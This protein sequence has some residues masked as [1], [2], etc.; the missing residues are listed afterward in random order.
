M[1][2]S[3][4]KQFSIYWHNVENAPVILDVLAREDIVYGSS[5]SYMATDLRPVFAEE[6]FLLSVILPKEFSDAWDKSIWADKSSHFFIDGKKVKKSVSQA[7]NKCN[8]DIL[9]KKVQD[10]IPS[11]DILLEEQEQIERFI[12]C[13]QLRLDKIINDQNYDSEGWP[14]GAVPFILEAV[15]RNKSR[16]PFVSFSGGKDST[17]VSHLVMQALSNPSIIHIFGDTTLE[18]PETYKYIYRFRSKHNRTPFFIE[19]NDASNFMDLCKKIGP[20][21]RVKSWCC[22]IFKTGPMGTTLADMGIDLLTFY[23]VRRLESTSRSKYKRVTPSPKLE[24]QHVAA[25]IIDWLDIDVWLYILAQKL[26]FNKAYRYGFSRVG[27][28]CC[29]NNSNW[30]DMLT[31]VY[32]PENYLEWNNFLVDF[33]RQIGKEDAEIY[34]KDGKWK[35]RH[36]GEGLDVHMTKVNS[37]NCTV[38]NNA[39]QYNLTRPLSNEF[40]ELFKPFGKLDFTLGR[41]Q[42]SEVFVISKQND[43]LLKISGAPKG[44]TVRITIFPAFLKLANSFVNI[45][46][47]YSYIERQIRKFQTCMYC[48]ACNSVCPVGAL[49]VTDGKYEI[50]DG[51]CIHC[52]KCVT[53]FPAGCLL[54]SALGTKNNMEIQE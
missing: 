51:K 53:H 22:S 10:F 38:E 18:F 13:N 50:N 35:A 23:G 52:L 41:A 21:S 36:G 1:A 32:N 44:R 29:P 46:N 19:R 42:L 16:H 12:R 49:K 17:V 40:Y 7:L 15:K 47:A 54:A 39:R 3:D 33:A 34:V 11:R 31:A 6:K 48:M 5:I 27:C 4:T 20:P 45:K 14:R 9:Q 28:W 25:P 26:D 30:S 24:M 37:K 8:I 43:M 2:N